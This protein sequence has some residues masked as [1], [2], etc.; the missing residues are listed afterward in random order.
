MQ[1]T[2]C[3]GLRQRGRT[4]RKAPPAEGVGIRCSTARGAVSPRTYKTHE[5][6]LRPSTKLGQLDYSADAR[7]VPAQYR[8][9]VSP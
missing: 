6:L 2:P 7:D 5:A 8:G 9:H 3:T 1:V 4:R